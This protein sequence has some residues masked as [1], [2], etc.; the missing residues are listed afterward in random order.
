MHSIVIADTSCFI[1]LDN[2]NELILLHK[3]YPKIITTQ[4]VADEFG[5]PLP[6]WVEVATPQQV[7]LKKISVYPIDEG[8]ITAI[9]L[10]MDYSDSV[11]IIDDLKARQV[12]EKFGLA[13]KGTIGIVVEAKLRKQIPSIKPLLEKINATNFRLS[14]NVFQAALKEA[15]EL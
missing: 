10:A 12:A 8:E 6:H 2:I 9:A 3:L 5:K 4:V 1:L 13:V 7:H 11:L 14:K 15:G